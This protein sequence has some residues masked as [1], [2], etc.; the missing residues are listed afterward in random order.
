MGVAQLDAGVRRVE[1][2]GAWPLASSWVGLNDYRRKPPSTPLS[3]PTTIPCCSFATSGASRLISSSLHP[4]HVPQEILDEII[5]TIAGSPHASSS[6]IRRRVLRDCSLVARSWTRRSQKYLFASVSLTPDNIDSW[7]RVNTKNPDTLNH[8][9]RFLEVK[10]SDETNTPKFEPGTMEAARPYLNFPNLETLCLSQWDNLGTFSLPQ[11]FGQ[12]STPLLRSLT[13]LDSI[14]NG[15]VLLELAA[16]FPSVDELI[17]DCAYTTDE[18]IT[19]TFSFPDC[20]RWRTL[21]L[22]SIDDSMMGVLDV[23]ASLHLQCQELDISYELLDN[24]GPIMRLIQACSA[25]LKSMRLEQTYS[26]NPTPI[27]AHLSTLTH[28]S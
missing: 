15:D 18:R 21:R 20:M 2:G 3:R 10:Q 26:G 28:R 12:Y 14:S 9:V 1:R 23:I 4:M 5:D 22:V 24:P 13:I 25:T 6:P 17:I 8:H 27:A 7:R 16:L 19:K 11:T